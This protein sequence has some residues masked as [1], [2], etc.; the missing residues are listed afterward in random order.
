[1][2]HV[3]AHIEV[4][5]IHKRFGGV[6][7]LRGVSLSIERA[8]IVGLVGE[9]GAGKSTLGKI[10]GGLIQP[11][12]G[13]VRIS[14]EEMRFRAPRDALRAGVAMITQELSIVPARSTVE[15]V[16]L[17][18]E[19]ATAGVVSKREIL[20][21]Y[22]SLAELT[23]FDIDPATRAGDLRVAEQIRVE[24]M[25][26]LARNAN[27][28]VMDEV[29]AALTF[30]EA[31]RLFEIV[32]TLRGRGT[33]IIYVSH[34][35]DE[36]LA[37][38]DHVHVMRDGELV[39]SGPASEETPESLVTAM[40]GRQLELTFPEK[41]RPAADAPVVFEAKGISRDGVLHG[42]DVSV[43]AGEIVGIAGLIGSGRSEFVRAIFGADRSDTGTIE[44]G[45]KQVKIKSPGDAVRAGIAMLP[46]SR[47]D[48]GLMLQRSIIENVTLPHLRAVSRGGVVSARKEA[49]E[50]KDLATRL[51][52]RTS[53]LS[54]QVGTLSGGNQQ[55]VLFAKWL[56]RRPV[57]LMADEPTRGVDVGAK[58]Q[59][60]ELLTSLAAEGLG[61]LLIS[62][63]LEEV[64]GL[65][66]R[67]LVMREGAIV[68]EFDGDDFDQ[69]QVMQAAFAAGVDATPR[70]AA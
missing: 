45:G 42:I 67:V 24:I 69:E 2:K 14:G 37:L 68:A 46:E 70:H 12:G 41:R 35:L 50:V 15:N 40:V 36:V 22:R 19:Q 38:V 58:L 1:V 10:I 9:N 5:D 53:S 64:L 49:A 20:K 57:V 23:G 13:H 54:A 59:I 28:I 52:V 63:E 31:K 4:E 33:T 39:K 3:S 27:A 6:H 32:Q 11:D 8:S 62:S 34:F 60:Y 16:F 51:D 44:V 47:K 66:H 17:G 61:V 30:D 29:T 21:R 26:A 43:R 56:L 25:R 7:A 55:K 48:Q 18:V 65:S